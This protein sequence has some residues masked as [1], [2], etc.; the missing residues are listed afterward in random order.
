MPKVNSEGVRINDLTPIP[1]E[2]L[3]PVLVAVAPRDF[4]DLDALQLPRPLAPLEYCEGGVEVD[5][6]L[7]GARLSAVVSLHRLGISSSSIRP[8]LGTWCTNVRHHP[9][10]TRTDAR[11]VVPG[12]SETQ[13]VIRSATDVVGVMVVLPVV[14]PETHG[15]DLVSA[16]LRQREVPATRTA[17]RP[18]APEYDVHECHQSSV[19]Q[20]RWGTWVRSRLRHPAPAPRPAPSPPTR[21]RSAGP[22]RRTRAGRSSLRWR[23]RG[24]AGP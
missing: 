7:H 10:R 20:S 23:W 19:P 15:T 17:V 8:L 4:G 22:G 9:L 12:S 1:V 5:Q 14:L 18:I 16:A 24:R 11:E 6:V 3:G 21:R 2:A 13:F